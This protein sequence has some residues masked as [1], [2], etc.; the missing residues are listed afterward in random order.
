MNDTGLLRFFIAGVMHRGLQLAGAENIRVE[1][2]ASD[3]AGTVCR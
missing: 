1:P 3:D 2:L